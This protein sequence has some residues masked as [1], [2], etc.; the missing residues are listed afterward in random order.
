MMFYI[1]ATNSTDVSNSHLAL[2][3]CKL[4]NILVFPKLNKIF[5]DN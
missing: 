3:V 1:H 5:Q 4:F 2:F